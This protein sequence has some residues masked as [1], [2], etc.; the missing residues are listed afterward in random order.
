MSWHNKNSPDPPRPA[1]GGWGNEEVGPVGGGAARR[2]TLCV[3]HRR[4]P[5]GK[6]YDAFAS[7][8]LSFL[9]PRVCM[10]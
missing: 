5:R 7:G 6:R 2:A 10:V 1:P 9:I 4:V 8:L 3:V